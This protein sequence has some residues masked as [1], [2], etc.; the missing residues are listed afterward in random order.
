MSPGRGTAT[1]RASRGVRGR[2]MGLG[3]VVVE[4][5]SS[6]LGGGEDSSLFLVF[7]LPRLGVG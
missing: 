3:L 4:D 5:I 7:F 2:R 6:F 1:A